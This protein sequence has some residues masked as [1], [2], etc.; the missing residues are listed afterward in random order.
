MTLDKN[1]HA[2]MDACSSKMLQ[3][4]SEA[5]MDYYTAMHTLG[6]CFVQLL[7]AIEDTKKAQACFVEVIDVVCKT[8]RATDVLFST[9]RKEDTTAH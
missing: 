4:L 8:M 1:R 9:D 7:V 6:L 2:Q 5:D 3:A